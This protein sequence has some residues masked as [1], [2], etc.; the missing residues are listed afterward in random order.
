MDLQKHWTVF[1]EGVDEKFIVRIRIPITSYRAL[2]RCIIGGKYVHISVCTLNELA[3]F[4]NA[5]QTSYQISM[6]FSSF[7]CVVLS[8][9]RWSILTKLTLKKICHIWLL[10]ERGVYL[11]NKF[12]K[13]SVVV[14]VV[15]VVFV[16]PFS[17]VCPLST[18]EKK[19]DLI[20]LFCSQHQSAN[21]LGGA[22]D[23][24]ATTKELFILAWHLRGVMRFLRTVVST[25]EG[26]G[27]TCPPCPKPFLTEGWLKT[28]VSVECISPS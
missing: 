28:V 6:R 16:F 21:S 22:A 15:A 8:R 12:F 4:Q 7:L 1:G 26:C 13:V 14:S 10:K 5:C 27:V 9:P 3:V 19:T 24:K 11:V 25:P 2:H 17:L 23:N 18:E 20:R